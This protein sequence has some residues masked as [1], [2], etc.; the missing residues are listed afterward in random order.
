MA[1]KTARGISQ[2]INKLH[3]ID[4]PEPLQEGKGY[5][6]E[7]AGTEI[8]KTPQTKESKKEKPNEL[9]I[10]DLLSKGKFEETLK[11]IDNNLSLL[12]SDQREIIDEWRKIEQE[13]RRLEIQQE[14]RKK[15]GVTEEDV[16]RR[17]N[18]LSQR[19]Q[20]EK[21]GETFTSNSGPII[22]NLLSGVAK[23]NPARQ[24]AQNNQSLFGAPNTK[25]TQESSTVDTKKD[26]ERTKIGQGPVKEVQVGD[27]EADI[28]AK[29][30]NLMQEQQ[31]FQNK[32]TRDEK[33][34]QREVNK[35][36]ENALEETIE[37]VSAVSN[38]KPS[39][40]S[41]KK[42]LKS[43]SGKIKKSRSPRFLQN[44][45]GIA[46]IGGDILLNTDWKEKFEETFKDAMK[47]FN[48]D[49]SNLPKTETKMTD[50]GDLLSLIR[51]YEAGSA[52]YHAINKGVAG[53]TPG[54]LPGLENMTINEVMKMQKEKKIFAAGAYQ[55]TPDTLSDTV[56]GLKLTGEE[57]FNKEIQDKLASYQIEKRA[58]SVAKYKKS[59]SEEDLSKAIDETAKI[60]AAIKNTKGTSTYE[61]GKGGNK[62]FAG[63]EEF[64]M[65]LDKESKP[66]TNL[67]KILPKNIT[68]PFGKRMLG[69]VSGEHGGVD[70]KGNLHDPVVS[71]KDGKVST[72]GYQEGGYGT[73]IEVDH[74]SGFKTRY[75][76]LS[77]TDVRV[78]DIVSAGQK[79]GEVGATGHVTGPHLHYE[80][81]KD[82]QKVDVTKSES[83]N[84]NPVVPDYKLSSADKTYSETRDMKKDMKVADA[85]SG[86]NIVNNTTNVIKPA[87]TYAMG[88]E[89]EYS[90]PP[91]L[92]KQYN[93]VD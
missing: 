67:A 59:G 39:K 75:A 19:A 22:S 26:P 81:L 12:S 33:K 37:S 74:G 66:T 23:P 55:F 61:G 87:T 9:V 15:Y 83:F 64:K 10:W 80:L 21:M 44:I 82:G 42:N 68:S 70:I 89:N 63:R 71:T 47:D 35:K 62:G 69:G 52:G 7:G 24:Q 5:S 17:D 32:K 56:K 11:L 16:Q 25:Q 79:I 84:L 6:T 14:L 57:K 2:L 4:K 60:W 90:Y 76:H 48:L 34:Y 18:I 78:G 77:K 92:K 85:S 31:S 88:E 58:P 1:G 38:I 54:G 49:L 50:T 53:D 36:K 29:M 30:Y 46:A 28:L 20:L 13:K 86:L 73:Y 40:I 91:L 41:K 3:G 8:K 45:Y 43:S 93:Y 65:S 51:K 27:G 72:V